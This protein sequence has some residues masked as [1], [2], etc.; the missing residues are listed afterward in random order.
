MSLHLDDDRLQTGDDI[1]VGFPSGVAIGQLVDI[2]TLPLL[3]KVLLDL[4]VGHAVAGTREELVQVVPGPRSHLHPFDLLVV[5]PDQDFG[6]L[7]ELGGFLGPA[8]GAGPQPGRGV[9][10][11]LVLYDLLLHKLR[12]AVSIIDTV[13]GQPAVAPNATHVV[14]LALAVTREEEG[15]RGGAEVHDE[16]AHLLLQITLDAV[17]DKMRPDMVALDVGPLGLSFSFAVNSLEDG[18][19]FLDSALVILFLKAIT[20]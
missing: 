20:R 18:A 16:V 19:I 1:Q 3:G 4:L 14:V 2:P 5:L 15:V 11:L 7:D 9:L 12:Q 17:Q 6:L 13:L 8:H 10:T